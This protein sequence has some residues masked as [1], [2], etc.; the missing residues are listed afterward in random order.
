MEKFLSFAYSFD[1][2]NQKLWPV[3]RQCDAG[4]PHPSFFSFPLSSKLALAG[5]HPVF[6]TCMVCRCFE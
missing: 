4:A 1:A 3:G 5:A 2:K 6:D